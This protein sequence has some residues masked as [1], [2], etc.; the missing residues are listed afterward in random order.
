MGVVTNIGK[1][2]LLGSIVPNID[3]KF[4]PYVSKEAAMEALDVNGQDCLCVGLTVGIIEDNKVVE[5]WFQGG[6]TIE[7]LVRKDTITVI[8]LDNIVKNDLIQ[9]RCWEC[10]F[11]YNEEPTYQVPIVY[12]D[13]NYL[14]VSAK[15][16]EQNENDNNSTTVTQKVWLIRGRQVEEYW[17]DISNVPDEIKRYIPSIIASKLY[18][19]EEQLIWD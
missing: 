5:Y 8:P 6:I 12:N 14:L 19:M 2:I 16:T 11:S 17:D 18:T 1:P 15:I 4:G 13:S 7:H 9:R 10:I 3:A